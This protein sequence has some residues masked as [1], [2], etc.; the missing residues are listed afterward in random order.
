MLPPNRTVVTVTCTDNALA[1][2]ISLFPLFSSFFQSHISPIF[3]KK[4]PQEE[5][6]TR[7]ISPGGRSAHRGPLVTPLLVQLSEDRVHATF[8]LT[9]P[10]ARVNNS[11]TAAFWTLWS[12][13]TELCT[14]HSGNPYRRLLQLWLTNACTSFFVPGSLW[15]TD[16]LIEVM[17]LG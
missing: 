13:C 1:S 7:R 11:L 17:W 14:S 9:R 12:R 2:P 3:F 5:F 16:W 15:M 10:L 8:M 4:I 6:P